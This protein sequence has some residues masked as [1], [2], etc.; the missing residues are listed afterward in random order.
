MVEPLLPV[1][2]DAVLGDELQDL[3][4]AI[5]GVLLLGELFGVGVVGDGLVLLGG[6][7][8]VWDWQLAVEVAL[9]QWQGDDAVGGDLQGFG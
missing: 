1:L 7:E 4:V 3:Y 9:G 5:V 6:V 8:D 2:G